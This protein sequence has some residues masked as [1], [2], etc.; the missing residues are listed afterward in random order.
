MSRA[1]SV[2]YHTSPVMLELQRARL[3]FPLSSSALT[4]YSSFSPGAA[5]ACKIHACD[6]Y[7]TWPAVECCE[8]TFDRDTERSVG[9]V[10]ISSSVLLPAVTLLLL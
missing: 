3:L 9:S 5:T 8:V 7:G 4:L 1:R 2:K 10:A 6:S